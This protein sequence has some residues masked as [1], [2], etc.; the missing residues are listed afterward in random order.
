MMQTLE[1]KTVLVV[2]NVENL[3]RARR[4]TLDHIYCF[5]RYAPQHRYVY[6]R[7]LLPITETL[8]TT[9]W[10]AVI[11]ES[12]ALGI[13]TIRPRNRFQ[14]LREAW[15]FLRDIPAVKLAFPQ[16]DA[17]H[18]AYL[19]HFCAYVGADAVFSVRPERKEQLYPRT[20]AT[21]EFVSTVAGYIDDQ[22]L[23]EISGLAQPFSERRWDVGQR[24]TMY[25]AWGGR[26]AR[27]KGDAALRMKQACR[28]RSLPE[29]I[30]TDPRDVFVGD[31][32]Y[33]FLGDCRFVIGA[34]GGHGIWDPYGAVQDEVNDYVARHPQASFEEVEKA[35]F[36]GLDGRESFPG[37]A[38]RVLEAAQMGCG[39]VLLEGAYR[40]F[41]RPGEHYIELKEDYS[42]LSDV[43]AQMADGD[44]VQEMIAATRR[45]LIENP[46]FRYSTLVERCFEMVDR[47]AYGR[48][49][50]GKPAADIEV[51]R[52]KHKVQ[53]ATAILADLRREGFRGDALAERA[54]MILR[55]QDTHAGLGGQEDGQGFD[56]AS[57]VLPELLRATADE[58]AAG[59]GPTAVPPDRTAPYLD[60]LEAIAARRVE[61]VVDAIAALSTAGH[62]NA[63]WQD[64]VRLGDALRALRRIATRLERGVTSLR[65]IGEAVD[66]DGVSRRVLGALDAL[67][68]RLSEDAELGESLKDIIENGADAVGVLR[69]ILHSATLMQIM[70]GSVA[71]GTREA[72][73]LASVVARGADR[74]DFILEII[75][76]TGSAPDVRELER[77]QR[78]VRALMKAPKALRGA[79][80]V[81]RLLSR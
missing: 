42:N 25:P 72:A 74:L 69:R 59:S 45:D 17:T 10:D 20:S 52:A 33:R 21:A 46:F 57:G 6:H 28:E 81:T 67:G 53:L 71:L 43:F 75:D 19:D 31:D 1:P 23:D 40:G 5:E 11:F 4:S 56:W 13:V 26:F 27:R 16:D 24:V 63:A 51:V 30:S 22:S 12:T 66:V 49:P 36:L 9:A 79:S 77:V 48:G 60:A 58:P 32:W 70:A 18:S 50:T 7:A 41:V 55:G 38:P 61:R 15:G 76:A 78:V 14:H 35:C 37:F 54:A 68:P 39:Q 73:D 64:V 47:K 44:R 62:P 29:N 3:A 8:R 80:A 34:E 65:D 2:H